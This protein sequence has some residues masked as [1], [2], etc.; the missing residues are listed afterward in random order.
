MAFLFRSSSTAGDDK[1]EAAHQ[2]RTPEEAGT[3]PNAQRRP[4]VAAVAGQRLAITMTSLDA[5]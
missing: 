2:I 1:M 3:C 4:A 5:G